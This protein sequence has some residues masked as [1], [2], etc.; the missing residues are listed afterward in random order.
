[1]HNTID[2]HSV[3]TSH[4]TNGSHNA[5]D[6]E[7]IDY[8]HHEHASVHGHDASSHTST[9]THHAVQNSIEHSADMH[10]HESSKVQNAHHQEDI[11][12]ITGDSFEKESKN[13]LPKVT[14]EVHGEHTPEIISETSDSKHA[15][16]EEH[17]HVSS[18]KP[19]T[20]P[21][22]DEPTHKDTVATRPIEVQ[23]PKTVFEAFKAGDVESFEILL[24]KHP[25]PQDLINNGQN[26]LVCQVARTN[27]LPFLEGTLMSARLVYCGATYM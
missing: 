13:A 14:A 15:H 26:P 20:E 18:V 6:D 27:D 25:N 23:K 12:L 16:Q 22:H 9:H 4:S 5:K 19:H 17:D 24:K 10:T 11:I 2:V 1:M 3:H 7:H 21:H 8:Q